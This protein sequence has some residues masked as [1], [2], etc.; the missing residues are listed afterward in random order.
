MEEKRIAKNGIEIY[1]GCEDY[2]IQNCYIYQS[3][4]AGITHQ[5]ST[6][7]NKYELK[8]ILYSDNLIEDCVYSVE[9]FLEKENGD[10]ESLIENC[11]ISGNVMI[12]SGYGWGQQRHNV[13]TPAHIK[14]WSYE[15]TAKDFKITDNVF[16]RAAY[17]MIHIVAMEESSLPTMRGNTY[18]QKMGNM[19]GQF[20]ANHT[21]EPP[22][23]PFDENVK[24][25]VAN[26]VGEIDGSVIAL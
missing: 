8:N 9:Y 18:A 10:T 15:N 16:L 25:T 7:G 5:I 20:G 21:A 17:R 1:G 23:L 11:K 3:Y 19:L 14:G 4:D 26:T 24:E 2:L 6:G 12:D 22:I 13:N